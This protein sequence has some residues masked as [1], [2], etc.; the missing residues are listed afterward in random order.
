MG[1]DLDV[2]GL[3]DEVERNRMPLLE[4]LRELR[5]RLMWS[6]AALTLGMMASLGYAEQIYDWL[7]APFINA[8]TATGV[9]GGLSMVNSPFEGVYTYLWVAFIGGLALASPMVVLQIW[10]FIAPGLYTSEK[11]LV[12][13][14][15]FSSTLLF[16]A[17][18]LFCYYLIF[19]FAFPWFLQVID[20]QANLSVAGYLE[21]TLKMM[22]AFGLSFQLP[23]AVF[24][25]ARM[26]LIDHH[27][28]VQYIRYAI[29]A[30]FVVAAIITPPDVLTQCLLALPLMFLY[31]VS[32]GVAWA[33][34]T[35]VH[36]PDSG[37]PATAGS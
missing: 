29:V 28:M 24:V 6:I 4:H 20:V 7:T 18:A 33:F 35:K 31:V 27:D 5:T 32:I 14:L 11:R 10:L 8:I 16:G 23:I 34:T 9:D 17:G 22:G 19:P 21:A 37:P 1:G 12:V 30:I 3:L 25:L 13:P 36:P 15:A 2:Q 26:G